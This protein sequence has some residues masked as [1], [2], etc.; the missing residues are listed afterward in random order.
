MASEKLVLNFPPARVR[1][2]VVYHL[3]KD[4]DLRVNIL[5]AS[6][7]PDE[8]GHMVV[9]IEGT[10]PQIE[11]GRKY[12][13][14]HGVKW[15]PLSKDVRWREDLCV[16]CTA[17]ISACPTGALRVDRASMTVSFDGEKCI[18]CEL[19]IPVCGYK[20]MEITF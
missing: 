18:G 6:I 16:H 20:A 11:K 4:F 9:E 3:V 7:G 12:I 14:S 13:E 10:R 19:C 2:P 17:C 1:Q 8:A 5:R 15:Q